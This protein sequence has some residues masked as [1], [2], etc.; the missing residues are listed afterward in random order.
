MSFSASPR[1]GRPFAAARVPCSES[2]ARLW[3]PLGTPSRPRALA[4]LPRAQGAFLRGRSHA[5]LARLHECAVSARAHGPSPPCQFRGQPSLQRETLHSIHCPFVPTPFLRCTNKRRSICYSSRLPQSV[6]LW[7]VTTPPA[8][9][10]CALEPSP[11]IQGG[12]RMVSRGLQRAR[13]GISKG[14]HQL[15]A[16]SEWVG[17]VSPFESA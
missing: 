13:T 6:E 3:H 7:H 5:S 10:R 12:R 4:W 1:A 14:L 9:M 17:N 16:V 15:D 8:A 2:R 11:S